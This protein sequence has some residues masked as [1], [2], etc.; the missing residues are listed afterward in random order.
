MEFSPLAFACP[1]RASGGRNPLHKPQVCAKGVFRSQ[2]PRALQRL[3]LI[4]F[5]PSCHWLCHVFLLLLSPYPA[6]F[7]VPVSGPFA[8]CFSS[9]CRH[10]PS[11]GKRGKVFEVHRSFP[12]LTSKRPLFSGLSDFPPLNIFL[13]LEIFA[14]FAPKHGFGCCSIEWRLLLTCRFKLRLTDDNSLKLL[15][16]LHLSR[17]KSLPLHLRV[18]L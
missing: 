10:L 3:A 1:R 12:V 6:P 8:S 16:P 7:V 9:S 4:H 11:G 14:P 13:K 15:D 2:S 18:E 17:L 5:F